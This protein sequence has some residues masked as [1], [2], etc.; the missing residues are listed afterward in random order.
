MELNAGNDSVHDTAFQGGHHSPLPSNSSCDP[1][2]PNSSGGASPTQ[3]QVMQTLRRLEKRELST[4]MEDL[5]SFQTTRRK[6]VLDAS[7]LASPAEVS[8]QILNQSA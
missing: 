4:I 1:E 6:L 3:G 5:S 2:C 7:S 8:D